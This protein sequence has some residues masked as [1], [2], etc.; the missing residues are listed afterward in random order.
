[1]SA[2]VDTNLII[3]IFIFLSIGLED[4]LRCVWPGGSIRLRA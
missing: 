2:T 3:F 1:M 4:R